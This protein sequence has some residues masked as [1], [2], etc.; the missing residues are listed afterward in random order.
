MLK[1]T[2]ERKEAWKAII[3]FLAIVAIISTPVYIAI[4]N[5]Y[6]SRIYVG[7]LMWCPAIAAIITLAIIGRPITSIHWNWANWKYIRWSYFIPAVYVLITYIFIW[8]FELGGLSNEENIME[9]AK[10]LGLVG[11]GTLKP[12]YV[13]IIGA[14]LLAT[15]GVIRAMAT[16]L[17]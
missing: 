5:L 3:I 1:K 16:V 2:S 15:V 17:G 6:P 11:I 8:V 10:E 7:A 9:W 13:I 4:V 12:I 14:I